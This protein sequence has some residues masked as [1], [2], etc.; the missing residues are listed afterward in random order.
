MWLFELWSLHNGMCC[1]VLFPRNTL[2][3]FQFHYH[4]SKCGSFNNDSERQR[5][6]IKKRNSIRPASVNPIQFMNRQSWKTFIFFRRCYFFF[7][8]NYNT[9]KFIKS[10]TWLDST[11][12][13]H[14]YKRTYSIRYFCKGKKKHFI[15]NRIV[16]I[17]FVYVLFHCCFRS[18]WWAIFFF[19]FFCLL[20]IE[21]WIRDHI[22]INSKFDLWDHI[23]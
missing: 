16:R 4:I 7:Q 20:S 6:R 21:T 14:T 18:R 15:Q 5:E 19:F 12:Y 2:M 10:S 23:F 1:L 3:K 11:N 13:I 22:T 9:L 8:L 17:V